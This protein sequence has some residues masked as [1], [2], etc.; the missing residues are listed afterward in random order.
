MS[1]SSHASLRLRQ[2][3]IDRDWVERLVRAPGWT[4]PDPGRPGL[5][6]AFGFVPEMARVVRIVV[7]PV[8]DD[9]HIATIFPNRKPQGGATMKIRSRT[10]D[11]EADAA[12]AY[13]TDSRIDETEEVAPGII[14]DHDAAGQPVGVEVLYVASR[15]SGADLPSYLAGLVEGLFAERLVAAE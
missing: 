7:R 12:Y 8:G 4:E 9:C 13:L 15:L 5:V 14:V 3:K 10:V 2:R 11:A 6:R 1:Y